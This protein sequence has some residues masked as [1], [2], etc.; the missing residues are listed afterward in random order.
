MG[1]DKLFWGWGGGTDKF[2][3]EDKQ[4]NEIE[5]ARG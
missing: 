5:K 1:T 3:K 4:G 2:Y